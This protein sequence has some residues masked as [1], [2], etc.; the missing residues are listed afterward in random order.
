MTE[1]RQ[2]RRR[3]VRGFCVSVWTL[4]GEPLPE[5]VDREIEKAVQEIVNK[6]HRRLAM[7]I[8]RG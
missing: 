2:N 8:K 5:R 7:S 1:Q 3:N 6:S 4:N